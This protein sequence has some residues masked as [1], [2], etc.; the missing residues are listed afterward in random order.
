MSLWP[1]SDVDVVDLTS[2]SPPRYPE[3]GR[4]PYPDAAGHRAQLIMR[5]DP[6]LQTWPA[7]PPPPAWPYAAAAWGSRGPTAVARQRFIQ[8]GSGAPRAPPAPVVLRASL[9]FWLYPLPEPGTELGTMRLIGIGPTVAKAITPRWVSGF[10]D[11]ITREL[12][13]SIPAMGRYSPHEGDTYSLAREASVRKTVLIDEALDQ[14]QNLRDLCSTN[15]RSS[16]TGEFDIHLIIIRQPECGP[17]EV[18]DRTPAAILEEDIEIKQE[19]DDAR[20]PSI[21]SSF[22]MTIFDLPSPTPLAQALPARESSLRQ[23]PP[24][25]APPAMALPARAPPAARASSKRRPKRP[26]AE[27]IQ[28]SQLNISPRQ[29]RRQRR[30]RGESE[31]QDESVITGRS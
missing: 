18:D 11:F 21:R 7:N 14:E 2:S 26:R 13:P 29:T 6:P 24:A 3:A 8:R 15:F 27:S 16:K 31:G 20:E 28:S 10:S 25:R 23:A 4:R 9:T 1:S 19:P 22:D 17:S 30:L 5:S 12:L